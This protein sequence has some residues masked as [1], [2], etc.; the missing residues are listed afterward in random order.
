MKRLGL[1]LLCCVL[2]A[3]FSGCKAS[4][5]A[6]EGPTDV[7]KID[8]TEPIDV[9]ETD[10]PD[11]AA[12]DF[13]DGEWI[14]VQPACPP[15]YGVKFWL[16]TG[17][18]YEVIQSDDAPTS[19]LAVSI[20][21]ASE[22]DGAITLSYAKGFGVCGTGLEERETVFNGH[23]ARQGF[24]DGKPLW[25]FIWLKDPK[26]CVIINSAQLWY[27]AYEAE[28]DRILSSVDFIYLETIA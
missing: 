14:E 28:I 17:W 8:T 7:Q 5:Q 27:D 6:A 25:D 20:H 15:S 12:S 18:T 21:P 19:D 1:L 13:T 2:L 10:A 9:P 26:D 11:A 24:Y 4:P 16:P 22:P 23:P 3:A